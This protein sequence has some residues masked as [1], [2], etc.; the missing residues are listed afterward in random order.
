MA[1][2]SGPASVEDKL[3]EQLSLL[4]TMTV[5]PNSDAER[6]CKKLITVI[7]CTFGNSNKNAIVMLA[8]L[9]FPERT[10]VAAN[11]LARKMQIDPKQLKAILAEL[12][13]QGYVIEIGKIN[14]WSKHGHG[15]KSAVYYVDYQ[16]F[17]MMVKYR[18]YEI[19]HRLNVKAEKEEDTGGKWVCVNEKCHDFMNEL[20]TIE[21]IEHKTN[22]MYDND[23]NNHSSKTNQKENMFYCELCH[24]PLCDNNAVDNSKHTTTQ[25]KI[26]FNKQLSSLRHLLREC[27]ESVIR[28]RQAM[29]IEQRQLEDRLER[30]RNGF[31]E[32]AYKASTLE[33]SSKFVEGKGALD[34]LSHIQHR[35]ALSRIPTNE[36]QCNP[37]TLGIDENNS[38]D[39]KQIDTGLIDEVMLDMKKTETIL[40]NLNTTEDNKQHNNHNNNNNYNNN[41][42]DVKSIM[43]KVNGQLMSLEDVSNNNEKYVELM[44]NE[45]FQMYDQ[46]LVKHGLTFVE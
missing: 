5:R 10:R 6:L 27:E 7:M 43:I 46:L 25:M 41:K 9:T 40:R 39:S 14:N 21:L 28:E 34:H 37:E 3:E 4:E 32:T 17:I 22:F 44:T 35:K 8:L 2:T 29:A 30:C 31:D 36:F 38:E 19:L 26:S 45:E 42:V 15:R 11:D 23:G 1:N 33:I 24:E 13:S 20:T 18:F 16:Y 12:K